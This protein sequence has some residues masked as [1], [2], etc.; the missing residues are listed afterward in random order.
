MACGN[1]AGPETPNQAAPAK[2]AGDVQE[3]ADNLALI[4]FEQL[5]H[6]AGQLGGGLAWLAVSGEDAYQMLRGLRTLPL[7]L[8]RHGQN[9]LELADWLKSNSLV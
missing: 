4:D 3:R 9:G 7:R 8:E 6:A 5:Q 1:F 2:L